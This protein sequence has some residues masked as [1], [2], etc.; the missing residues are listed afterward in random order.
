M[1][2]V[3]SSCL[4]LCWLSEQGVNSTLFGNTCDK[5][6]DWWNRIGCRIGERLSGDIVSSAYAL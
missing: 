4:R 5:K 6:N 1:E 2:D 3:K